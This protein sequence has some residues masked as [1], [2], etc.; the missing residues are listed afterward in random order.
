MKKIGSGC[1]QFER[2]RNNWGVSETLGVILLLALV[3]I[4]VTI[5]LT[6]GM[7]TITDAKSDANYNGVEQ[8]FT[9]AE[10][11]LSKARFSTSIYQEAPFEL[12][13]GRRCS[14]PSRGCAS[15][16]AP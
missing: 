8:A 13:D 2:F 5:V 11:K 14:S 16:T 9:V 12:R 6:M 7:H 4:G 3:T 1:V 15:T 10:S